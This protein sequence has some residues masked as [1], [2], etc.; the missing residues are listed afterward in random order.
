MVVPDI[1]SG[2]VSDPWLG[3][4]LCLRLE[5]GDLAIL[6]RSLLLLKDPVAGFVA[7]FGGSWISVNV[8]PVVIM[9][10]CL[11]AKYMGGYASFT[12]D[13]ATKATLLG[14]RI[15]AH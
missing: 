1:V 6:E 14:V 4:C 13:S 10:G 5:V 3:T 9:A 15:E 11:L 12:I 2:S 7:S 8:V